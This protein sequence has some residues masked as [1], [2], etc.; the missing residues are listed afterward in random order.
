MPPR[1]NATQRRPR[2]PGG[3]RA[4]RVQRD[5]RRAGRARQG[6]GPEARDGGRVADLAGQIQR[7]SRRFT[8]VQFSPEQAT[9]AARESVELQKQG[10]STNDATFA[11]MATALRTMRALAARLAQQ[12]QEARALQNGFNQVED[13]MRQHQHSALN[14]GRP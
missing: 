10:L 6:P 13:F 9:A 5:A 4:A 1:S 2:P 7:R 8:G 12:R 3:R 14:S 11:A